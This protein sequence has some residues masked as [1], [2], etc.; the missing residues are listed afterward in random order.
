MTD[1]QLRFNGGKPR[2]HYWHSTVVSDLV[3]RDETVSVES[4]EFAISSWLRR[5]EDFDDLEVAVQLLVDY[6]GEDADI[7][8]CKVCEA[9]EAKYNRGNFRKGDS[10]CAYLDSTLRHL[11]KIRVEREVTDP[12]TECLHAAH[13][14]WNVIEAYEQPAWRDDRLPLRPVTP[15]VK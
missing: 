8:Y 2:L 1:K 7:E 4:I 14:L 15:P 10:V 11:R 3:P 5:D 13:A 6:I 12:E 9:G